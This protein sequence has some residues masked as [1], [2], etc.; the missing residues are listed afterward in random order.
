MKGGLS[1]QCGIIRMHFINEVTREG[2]QEKRGQPM[3]SYYIGMDINHKK[4]MKD[5][6]FRGDGTFRPPEQVPTT[7]R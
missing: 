2:P 4:T 7:N 5:V 6:T 1:P 3:E